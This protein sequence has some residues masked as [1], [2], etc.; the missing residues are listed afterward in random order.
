MEKLPRYVSQSIRRD[1]VERWLRDSASYY[2]SVWDR[3]NMDA[4]RLGDA[5]ARGADRVGPDDHVKVADHACR[6]LGIQIDM[7]TVEAADAF[8]GDLT[9]AFNADTK[10]SRRAA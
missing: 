6:E 1:A 8:L 4:R 5:F 9:R 7:E 2:Q 3:K 10:F